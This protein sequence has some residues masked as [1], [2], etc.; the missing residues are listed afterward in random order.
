MINRIIMFIASGMLMLSVLL[1]ANGSAMA[2]VDVEKKIGQFGSPIEWKLECVKWAIWHVPEVHGFNIKMVERKD[3]IGHAYK[4]LQHSFFV[5]AKGPDAE[6]AAVQ[7]LQEAMAAAVAAT[8]GT[9]ILTPSPEPTA[10]IAAAIVAGKQA[11]VGY[12]AARGFE[13]LA[14]QYDLRVDHRTHW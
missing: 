2:A 9:G 13:R 14:S 10:R 12:L 7:V 8:V 1:S 4:N 3:C 6:Q 5:V 11:F